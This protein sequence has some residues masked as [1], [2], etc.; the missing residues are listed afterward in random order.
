MLLLKSKIS[1]STFPTEAERNHKLKSESLLMT[2]VTLCL[3]RSWGEKSIEP[4][5][6]KGIVPEKAEYLV[7]GRMG[8]GK[9]PG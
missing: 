7:V 5:R 3:M 2:H 1:I 4:K 6:Q 9:Y 8:K